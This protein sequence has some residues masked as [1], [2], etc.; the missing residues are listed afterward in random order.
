[1]MSFKFVDLFA[2]LG[3][4]HVALKNLG[5]EGVFAA[6]WDKNLKGLYNTNFGVKPWGDLNE[7]DSEAKIA[8]E[9]PDHEVLTAGFPCQPFSKAGEQLGFEH[10]LQG[11]LFFK[12]FEILKVKKPK[13]FILE[14]V[15]NIL[16]HDNGKTLEIIKDKLEVELGYEVRIEKLSPHQFGVPQIRERAYFVGS[17]DGLDNFRWPSVSEHAP[18]IRSVVNKDAVSD[19]EIP[20]HTNYAIDMWNDF[21]SCSGEVKLPSFPIWSMEFGATYPF[22]HETPPALW[23]ERGQ[24][25]L[26]EYRGVFGLPLTGL[27]TSDQF[28]LIPS[29]SRRS[30]DYKFPRWKRTFIR[31]NREF[32]GQNIKWIQPWLNKWE[33]WTLPS[34]FQKFEWNA[35]GES[36]DID[37]FVLQVRA[38]GIR[39]KRTSTAPSL[40]AMTNTQVPILGSKIA[41]TRRYMTPG[42]CAALQS[43]ESIQLPEFDIH[44]YKALGNAVNARVVQKIAEPLLAGLG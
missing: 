3:G 39:V 8:C 9:V 28:S 10:T 13:R 4:F 43:M 11:Q 33:P 23:D 35:Q 2:G 22:E 6:E 17:L 44:A 27:S 30:G 37:N 25:G 5:G 16:K 38:S 7:L 18:D 42:E 24:V 41:G 29:H 34:S 40:I 19:R 31:Q 15:P 1:M 26:S 12:V 20:E 14:N 36:R 21:L 32:Y